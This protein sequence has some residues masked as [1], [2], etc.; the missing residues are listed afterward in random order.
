MS[1]PSTKSISPGITP[2]TRKRNEASTFSIAPETLTPN[3]FGLISW[4]SSNKH[5][6]HCQISSLVNFFSWA[7]VCTSAAGSLR[8]QSHF[9]GATS[10]V[11]RRNAAGEG[12]GRMDSDRWSVVLF[13][14]WQATKNPKPW[15]LNPKPWRGRG[16][17]SLSLSLSL[18]GIRSAL[19]LSGCPGS[20]YSIR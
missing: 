20:I 11:D 16:A 6:V 2:T 9:Q 19:S 7:D 5:T 8:G 10:K 17:L 3:V 14:H 12:E 15:A 18:S 1:T 13:R 4:S